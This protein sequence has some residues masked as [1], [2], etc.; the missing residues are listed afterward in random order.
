[1]RRARRHPLTGA[2]LA[3]ALALATAPGHAASPNPAPFGLV[4]EQAGRD[5]AAAAHLPRGLLLAIGRVESGRYSATLGRIAPWPW[6]VDVAGTGVLFDTQDAA[7]QTIRAAWTNGQHNIDV[8]C[9]QVNLRAHPNAFPDLRTAL[10]P[11]ANARFAAGFLA[12]LHARLGSWPAAAAAY[13]SETAALARPYLLAVMRNWAG[14][15]DRDPAPV[16]DR[17][18]VVVTRVPGPRVVAPGG[19]VL[20]QAGGMRIVTP[21]TG[22]TAQGKARGALPPWTPRQ[23]T[24]PLDPSGGS[25][26]VGAGVPAGAGPVGG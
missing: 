21:G 26:P 19:T 13:H 12:S 3:A 20:A 16:P 25:V 15:T 9:F 2:S 24:S 1:M 7:M 18:W 10:D 22:M 23:G 8:G 4:C 11:T 17:T 14:A 5:A 6:A